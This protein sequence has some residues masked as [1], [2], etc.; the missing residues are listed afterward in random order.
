MSGRTY[1]RYSP[2]AGPHWALR[3]HTA[4]DPPG[5]SDGEGG[6]TLGG[7][8]VLL[9][10]RTG[11]WTSRGDNSWLNLRT[12]DGCMS[13]ISSR[14]N[15]L[16]LT[17]HP[18]G[19]R[20]N[21]YKVHARGAG[22]LGVGPGPGGGQ[23][24]IANQSEAGAIY[25]EILH[26]PTNPSV[27]TVF[28]YNQTGRN[29]ISHRSSGDGWMVAC[30]GSGPAGVPTYSDAAT[31]DIAYTLVIIDGGGGGDSD[32]SGGNEGEFP[33]AASAAEERHTQPQKPTSIPVATTPPAPQLSL[34]TRVVESWWRAG[35]S[36]N[37]WTVGKF[38]GGQE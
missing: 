6:S 35:V 7:R 17:L 36:R 19:D 22:W 8:S 20:P 25:I 34:I 33:P 14:T 23:Q 16:P 24:V 18:V 3:R 32:G 2:P 21:T 9:Q 30:Y 28:L 11:H 5:T 10:C 37:E 12:T 26:D 38:C 29:Y 31:K 1:P 13:A 15:A 4:Q 27:S